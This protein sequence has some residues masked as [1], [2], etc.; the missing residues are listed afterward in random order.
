MRIPN[1]AQEIID[2]NRANKRP[3]E[4]V[5]VS[6]VGNLPEMNKTLVVDGPYYDWR[7]VY[8]LEICIFS[9]PGKPTI[10][11][12]MGIGRNFPGRLYVWDVENREGADGNVLLKPESIDKVYFMPDDWTVIWWPWTRWQ[13]KKF[14]EV[15]R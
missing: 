1:G 9:R 11:T 4:M 7:F 13:N 14:E 2:A 5:I 8:G 6:L 10:P 12:A 15:V 3:G